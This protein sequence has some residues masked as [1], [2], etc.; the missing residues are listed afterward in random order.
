VQRNKLYPLRRRGEKPGNLNPRAA[1][2]ILSYRGGARAKPFSSS[3][4]AVPA[5]DRS[6]FVL[7]RNCAST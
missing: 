1:G 2:E 4:K 7:D 5:A 6:L 3:G